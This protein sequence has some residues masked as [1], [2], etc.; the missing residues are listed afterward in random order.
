MVEEKTTKKTVNLT[1]PIIIGLLLVVAFL[2]GMQVKDLLNTRSGAMPKEGSPSALAESVQAPSPTPFPQELTLGSFVKTG[3][4]LCRK[5]GRPSVY[6]FGSNSCPHC[7]WEHPVFEAVVEKFGDEVDFHNNMDDQ[8]S[9]RDV[10]D[11]YASIN[12]GGVP[13]MVLGCQYARVGSGSR[14]GEETESMNLTALICKL[15]DN[16]PASV[17]AEA[18]DLISQI[19]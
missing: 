8:T 4:E 10:W 19:N 16:Q 18:E 11:R 13:F 6:F 9:D 3:D 2:G 5:D 7:Q 14:M 15:T 1:K 12:R 17:C